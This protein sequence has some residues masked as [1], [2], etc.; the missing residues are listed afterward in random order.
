[1]TPSARDTTILDQIAW[2]EAQ[3]AAQRRTDATLVECGRMSY[4]EAEQRMRLARATVASVR[5]LR[6]GPTI[7]LPSRSPDGQLASDSAV[8]TI[9][10][11][12]DA[13]RVVIENAAT[14]DRDAARCGWVTNMVGRRLLTVIRTGLGR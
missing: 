7:T 1:M 2:V 9:T 14:L 13:E 12:T 6:Q 4:L 8:V 11:G 5:G 10:C 3:A